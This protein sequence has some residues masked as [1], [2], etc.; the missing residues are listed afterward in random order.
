MRHEG[1]KQGLYRDKKI[2]QLGMEGYAQ[3]EARGRS[4]MKRHDAIIECMIFLDKQKAN[5]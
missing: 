5:G 3:L 1:N 2:K 4:V